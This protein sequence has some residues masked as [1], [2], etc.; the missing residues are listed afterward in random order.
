MP[1]P[2][3]L[4]PG[5][6]WRTLVKSVRRQL[7]AVPGNGLGFGALRTFGPP[8][9]RERLGRAAHGQVVFNYLGQWD[10]RPENPGDGLV[11][12]EHGS[13]GRHHDPRD[14]GSHPLEVV[15]A[16]QG[17]RLS[18][19]WHHRPALHATDAVRRVAEDFA[20]ALRHI[21]HHARGSR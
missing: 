4:G 8:E 3:D 15:G 7:R 12:A 16:V 9:V 11:R 6:D 21:A 14:T 5:R 19:T 20:E 17:G 13:F 2:A 18:F 1:D 10:A